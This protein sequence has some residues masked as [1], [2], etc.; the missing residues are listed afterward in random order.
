LTEGVKSPIKSLTDIHPPP[1]STFV[2]V[3]V[4]VWLTFKFLC[5][6]P[7]FEISHPF[8][9]H[10]CC[11]SPWAL[12]GHCA[13]TS[14][15][16]TLMAGWQR[17]ERVQWQPLLEGKCMCVGLVIVTDKSWPCNRT[18]FRKKIK[19]SDAVDR[20]QS[21]SPSHAHTQ[22]RQAP[23]GAVCHAQAHTQPEAMVGVIEQK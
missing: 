15:L 5:Y 20:T 14:C 11:V 2:C 10:S 19:Q 13:V 7:T 8:I 17:F 1:F 4:C 3:C 21:I 18:Q 22:T 16:L 9:P 6:I 23:T 12:E